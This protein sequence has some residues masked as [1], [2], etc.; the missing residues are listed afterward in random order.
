M[1]AYEADGDIGHDLA[2]HDLQRAHGRGQQVFHGAALAL[3]RH[4]QARHH[5]Q[6]HAQDHAHQP[7]HR[8]VLGDLLFVVQ[9][10]HAHFERRL[11]ARQVRQRAGQVFAG[12]GLAELRS[13]AHRH[14]GGHGVGGV[15]LDQQR[16]PLAAQQAAR[17]TGRNVQ[18][19][20]HPALRQRGAPGL[21]VGQFFDYVEVIGRLHRRYEGACEFAV[22][23]HDH[24]GGHLLRIGVDGVAEQRQLHDGNAD[25]HAESDAVAA[26][27]Q[28]FLAHHAPPA[29]PRK[30]P[31]ADCHA[32]LQLSVEWFIR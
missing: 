27:L 5:D 10:V 14:A 20:Q 3:A 7:R 11:A 23:G 1:V 32:G 12:H 18:H 13:R 21:F 8:V 9:A 22:V 4:G 6:R 28:E 2:R 31:F 25:D 15:G 26:Q 24:R 29:R 17:E 16:G 19:E 30:T